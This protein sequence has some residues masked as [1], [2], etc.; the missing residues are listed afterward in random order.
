MLLERA[1]AIAVALASWAV[2]KIF[3]AGVNI[4]QKYLEKREKNS[5]SKHP[6]PQNNKNT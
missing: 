2:S 4:A 5:T 3:D 6:E 1:I